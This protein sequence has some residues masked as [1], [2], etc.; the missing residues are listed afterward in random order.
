V[1]SILRVCLVFVQVTSLP[2]WSGDLLTNMYSGYLNIP[3]GK[4]LHYVFVES[5][6]NPATDPVVAWFNGMFD[7]SI[8]VFC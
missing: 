2:G 7:C 1:V 3:G 5:L 4:H 8:F 6:N